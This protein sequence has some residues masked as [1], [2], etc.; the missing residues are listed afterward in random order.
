MI[1]SYSRLLWVIIA[2]RGFI[3]QRAQ[4]LQDSITRLMLCLVREIPNYQ[5]KTILYSEKQCFSFTIKYKNETYIIMEITSLYSDKIA[6]K[7]N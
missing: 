2:I 4:L 6:G 3:I 5:H 1:T 7:Y